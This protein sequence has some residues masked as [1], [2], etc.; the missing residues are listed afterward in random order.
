MSTTATIRLQ[1]RGGP[2][3][4]PNP[5]D[6]GKPGSKIPVLC[7]RAGIPVA[8]GITAANTP[9]GEALRPL[10]WAIPAVRSRCGQ[11]RRRPGKLHAD[12]AYDHRELRQGVTDCGIGVR[13]GRKGVESSERL[14]LRRW[15]IERTLPWLTGYH[16][17]TMRYDRKDTYFCGFLT[18]AAALTWYEKLGKDR[19]TR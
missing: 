6:L 4:A 10:V 15:V 14:D 19:S 16:R 3:T 8:V 9:D 1:Q 13:I 2:L 17:L 18:L 5:V 7:N 12:K 11:R